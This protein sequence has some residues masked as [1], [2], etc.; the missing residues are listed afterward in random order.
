[1]L[2]G[3]LRPILL[4]GAVFARA[5]LGRDGLHSSPKTPPNKGMAVDLSS[6]R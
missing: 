4:P 2:G 6:P 1:M 5:T 3:A